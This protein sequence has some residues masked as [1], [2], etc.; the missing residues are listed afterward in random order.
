MGS[1]ELAATQTE[2]WDL[3]RVLATELQSSLQDMKEG[4]I[5]P[6]LGALVSIQ[7]QLVSRLS[8][9]HDRVTADTFQQ[10]SNELVTFMYLR[11]NE[12]YEVLI[13]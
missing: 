4:E 7:G 8:Q 3:S 13:L 9:A 12:L 1:A 6:L 11:Q 10:T 5:V 2:H